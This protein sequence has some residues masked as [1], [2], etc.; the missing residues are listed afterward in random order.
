[1]S[2]LLPR[3]YVA[4]LAAYNDGHLHGIWLDADQDVDI[5]QESITEM[6]RLSPESN[7]EEHAIHDVE[8]FGSLTIHEYESLTTVSAWAKFIV[9]HGKIG[10]E[11]I[12]YCSG[13]ID[14]AVTVMEDCY[15]GAYNSEPDFVEEFLDQIGTQ[16]P[17]N[18]R[19]YV[20]YEKMARDWFISDFF[21]LK[22]DGDVHVFSS[23]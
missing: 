15:H 3:I 13:D 20:D 23:Y 4:C 7:A 2:D 11:L 18:L 5:L 8:N 19:W 21:S 17:E 12:A 1:M 22:V 16:I 9:E 14:Q 10:A 6:L